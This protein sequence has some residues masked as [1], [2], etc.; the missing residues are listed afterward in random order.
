[1]LIASG[2]SGGVANSKNSPLIDKVLLDD[3]EEYL[4]DEDD[5]EHEIS[6][7]LEDS[8]KKSAIERRS[9]LVTQE[10]NFLDRENEDD[11]LSNVSDSEFTK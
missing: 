9:R 10:A 3:D 5:D 8:P 7:N 11:T 2:G 6:I 4:D 1:M